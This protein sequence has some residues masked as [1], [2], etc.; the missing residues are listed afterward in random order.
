MDWFY[1]FLWQGSMEAGWLG[2]HA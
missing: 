1:N 2:R